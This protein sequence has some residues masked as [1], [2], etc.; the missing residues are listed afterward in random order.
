MLLC[1][2]FVVVVWFADERSVV[3]LTSFVLFFMNI[4]QLCVGFVNGWLFCIIPA[5]LI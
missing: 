3:N 5:F 4:N 2:F 1:F